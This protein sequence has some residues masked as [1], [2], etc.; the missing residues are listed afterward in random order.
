MTRRA[1][2]PAA[3]ALRRRLDAELHASAKRQNTTLEWTLE[4]LTTL[5]LLADTVDRREQVQQAWDATDPADRKSLVAYS[6]EMRLIDAA[7][8]RM[9]KSL[10][11]EAASAKP[12]PSSQIS[13]HARKAALA[14]WESRR[15]RDAAQ[16]E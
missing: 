2:T 1:H 10:D 9:V 3:R 16:H 11:P 6:A 12:T 5:D 4:E 7:I 13:Q 8:L 14:S 15:S